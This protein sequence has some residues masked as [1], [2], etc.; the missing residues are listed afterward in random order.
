MKERGF[1]FCV[2]IINIKLCMQIP[3]LFTYL[4]YI[5]VFFKKQPALYVPLC[6]QQ[7]V[8]YKNRGVILISKEFAVVA[9]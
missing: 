9:E 7:F 1:F 6:V 8:Q 4:K 2:N 3:I 5:F